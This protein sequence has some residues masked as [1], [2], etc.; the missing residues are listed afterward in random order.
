MIKKLPHLLFI[1]IL[2][3]CS[4]TKKEKANK[5]IF[6][7]PM[8]EVVIDPVI[9][10]SS[11]S[12][13]VEE[14]PPINLSSGTPIL[15]DKIHFF[16]TGEPYVWVGFKDGYDWKAMDTLKRY[17]DSVIFEDEYEIRRTRYP[18]KEAKEYLDLKL[19]DSIAIFNFIHQFQGYSRLKRIE[20]HED[21]LGDQF[22][23]LLEPSS[24]LEGDQFYGISGTSEF[25]NQLGSN[26][27]NSKN[28]KERVK[29]HPSESSNFDWQYGAIDL[30]PYD[31]T[32]AFYS[33]LADDQKERTYLLELGQSKVETLLKET[34][35]YSI[36]DITPVKIQ[37]NDRP[38]LLLWVGYAETD[39]EWY[40]PAVYNG[41]E[42]EVTNNRIIQLEKEQHLMPNDTGIKIIDV[43]DTSVIVISLDSAEIETI[44]RKRGEDS[45]YTG[46]DDLMFYNAQ[47]LQLMDSLDIEVIYSE[48]DST[49]VRKNE[50]S[51]LITK[52]STFSIYTYFLIEGDVPERKDLFDLLGY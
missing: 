23:A 1:L 48:W 11:T 36:L 16:E 27:N 43:S 34:G 52:D 18:M 21:V 24:E 8:V 2:L 50:V 31:I 7:I 17:A 5:S 46:A 42:Y 13:I 29:Q 12:K 20:Y 3:S 37:V 51:T 40:T 45:F 19:L 44:K 32:Y 47:M 49:E 33:F 38:V 6:E 9:I 26:I 30:Q 39:I 10:D 4:T 14:K 41:Q 15:I 28:V 25:N 35:E 22:I